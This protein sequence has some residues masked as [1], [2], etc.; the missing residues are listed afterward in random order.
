MGDGEEED[1]DD[2]ESEEDH[3][4]EEWL[5][6]VILFIHVMIIISVVDIMFYA[7]L[8]L[9]SMYLRSWLIQLNRSYIN[10]MRI[11]LAQEFRL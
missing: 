2:E 9:G 3:K 5:L 11:S 8:L 4:Q 7:S 10:T 1:G 6:I